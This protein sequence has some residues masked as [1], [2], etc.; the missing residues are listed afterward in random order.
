ML[1]GHVNLTHTPQIPRPPPE[2]NWRSL[3]PRRLRTLSSVI[4]ESHIMGMTDLA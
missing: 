1:Y 3:G 4:P 2:Q